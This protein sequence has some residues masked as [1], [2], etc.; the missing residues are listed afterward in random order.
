MDDA[1]WEIMAKMED[2]EL[3]VVVADIVGDPG[4]LYLKHKLS[5]MGEVNIVV[6]RYVGHPDYDDE[7]IEDTQ[8]EWRRAFEEMRHALALCYQ[9]GVMTLA[10]DLWERDEGEL[11]Q[12]AFDSL[13]DEERRIDFAFVGRALAR[14]A[15][16]LESDAKFWTALAEF[17]QAQQDHPGEDLSLRDAYKRHEERTEELRQRVEGAE[18]EGGE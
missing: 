1:L 2:R 16:A 8:P 17:H 14:E 11:A 10:F 9:P 3:L 18:N 5:V 6:E 15:K 13:S 4:T 7:A 12:A